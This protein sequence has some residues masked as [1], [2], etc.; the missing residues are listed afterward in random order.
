MCHPFAAKN[1]WSTVADGR[2]SRVFN[3]AV[4]VTKECLAALADTS[5]SGRRVARELMALVEC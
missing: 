2:R 1:D 5:L 3:V 4:D